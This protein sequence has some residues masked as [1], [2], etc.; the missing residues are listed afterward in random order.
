[1]PM[2]HRLK[3]VISNYNKQNSELIAKYKANHQEPYLEFKTLDIV[4]KY[5]S[6][7]EQLSKKRK[8]QILSQQQ[9]KAAQN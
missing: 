6:D 2:V 4:R 9:R 8:R 7:L 1:M 5:L 3:D